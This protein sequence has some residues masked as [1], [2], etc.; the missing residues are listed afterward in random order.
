MPPLCLVSIL[1]IEESDAPVD[2]HAAGLI[3]CLPLAT[4]VLLEL[5]PYLV[6]LPGPVGANVLNYSASTVDQTI[7]D[8]EVLPQHDFGTFS[9]LQQRLHSARVFCKWPGLLRGQGGTGANGDVDGR[10]FMEVGIGALHVVLDVAAI[11]GCH[12]CPGCVQVHC[13]RCWF[14][15]AM[16]LN[17][18]APQGSKIRTRPFAQTKPCQK[19]CPGWISPCPLIPFQ[20]T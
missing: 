2:G 7:L 12:G 14:K 17:D 11:A 4:C 8:I 6:D 15:R 13:T 20:L 16:L 5:D 19:A 9:K 3:G 10:A 18:P 1:F